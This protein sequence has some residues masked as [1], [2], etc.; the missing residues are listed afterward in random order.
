MWRPTVSDYLRSSVSKGRRITKPATTKQP[1]KRKGAQVLIVGNDL[2]NEQ[3]A[4]VIMA[5]FEQYKVAE[6]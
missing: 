6:P 3:K 4:D 5:H 2:T 1:D